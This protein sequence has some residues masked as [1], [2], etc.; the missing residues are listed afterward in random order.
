MQHC[1]NLDDTLYNLESSSVSV[2]K[3][4]SYWNWLKVGFV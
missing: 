2:N 4:G 3:S 1:F